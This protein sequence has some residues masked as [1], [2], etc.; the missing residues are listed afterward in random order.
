LGSA[1]IGM[2][3]ALRSLAIGI[4][5]VTAVSGQTVLND[6]KK[7]A[8]AQKLF[9]TLRGEQLPCEVAQ[10]KPHFIFSLRLQAG[11][12]SRLPLTLA[13]VQGQKW[14]VLTEIT[15]KEGNGNPVYLSDVVQFPPGGN[16]SVEATVEGS[17]WLGEGIYSVR[18]LM[19]DARGDVCRKEWRIDAR[20]DSG[21][22]HLH[23]ILAPGT[24]GGSPGAGVAGA[25]G[26]RPAGQVTILL[27]AASVLQ[28]QTILSKL[29]TAMLLDS[30]VALMEEMPVRAVRLVVFNLEQQK[31]LLRKDGFTLEALPEVAQVLN[32]LQPAA[33]D[34]RAVQKPG[35]A[36]N[37]IE[38][39]VK[40]EIHASPPPSAVVFL[41]PKSIYKEKPSPNFGPA[42]GAKL[43]FFYLQSEPPLLHRWSTLSGWAGQGQAMGLPAPTH[44]GS[45]TGPDDFPYDVRWTNYG[46]NKGPDSIEYSVNKLRGKTLV[47]NSVDSFAE[48]VAKIARLSE[49][50]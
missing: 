19:L 5:A 30:L 2:A 24:V 31:E 41:G 21:V 16:S 32:S 20:L 40:Q 34:Y 9:E 4:L 11:Y 13:Q 7:I 3:F 1:G 46:P 28:M 48:S 12:V 45:A 15:P 49:N 29:D 38:N 43:Q 8:D 6:P 42:P 35:G 44:G 27:H 17:Y 26:S 23:S 36:A 10:L 22:R 39:L 37:F 50:R 33:V 25:A 47:V 14:I 18:F